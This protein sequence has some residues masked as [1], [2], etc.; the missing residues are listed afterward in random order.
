MT[1]QVKYKSFEATQTE[2]LNNLH[3]CRNSQMASVAVAYNQT[4]GSKNPYLLY[5][6]R[7]FGHF[8]KHLIVSL[9]EER[10]YCKVGMMWGWVNQ[11]KSTLL[12]GVRKI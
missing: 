5:W 4:F 9:M 2:T 1:L 3:F 11:K 6:K 12:F 10:K 7:Q 8:S